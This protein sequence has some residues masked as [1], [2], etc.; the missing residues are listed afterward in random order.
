MAQVQVGHRPRLALSAL[1]LSCLQLTHIA[2]S[3]SEQYKISPVAALRVAEQLAE[4]WYGESAEKCPSNVV[5]EAVG[6][7]LADNPVDST[8]DYQVAKASPKGRK[9]QHHVKHPQN[10]SE[11]A[12]GTVAT[13]CNNGSPRSIT[14]NDV[15]VASLRRREMLDADKAAVPSRMS[16]VQL[17]SY[18]PKT[19]Y[20]S[21]MLVSSLLYNVGFDAVKPRYVEIPEIPADERMKENVTAYLKQLEV[22]GVEY[23]PGKCA[24]HGKN[25]KCQGHPTE[26]KA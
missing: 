4:E 7:S 21:Q 3:I 10:S 26:T 18:P 17:L 20:C 13:L 5:G 14:S 9:T 12:I 2:N 25:G 16:V 22:E 8:H 15:P 1:E 11:A 19:K 23:L 24:R 6:E